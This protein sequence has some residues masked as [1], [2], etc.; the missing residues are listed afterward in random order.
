[1]LRAL[2]LL[3][4]A[5]FLVPPVEPV[6]SPVYVSMVKVIA[7]PEKFDQRVVSLVG[8]LRVEAEGTAL[9]FS[10]EDYQHGVS[11]NALHVQLTDQIRKDVEKLDMNYVR[12]EGA[13]DARHL[14]NLPFP[15]GEITRLSRCDLWSQLDH[16]RAQKYKDL[17]NKGSN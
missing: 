7:N 12:L 8:F 1:M 16:P 13:F 6:E 9:Y 2:L 15:S 3:V 10:A 14:G 4:V 11:E 5:F 17:W